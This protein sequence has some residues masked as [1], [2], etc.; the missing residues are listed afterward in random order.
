[1]HG[2]TIKTVST[3]GTVSCNSLPRTSRTV[4]T[5]KHSLTFAAYRC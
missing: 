4:S 3:D 2:A 1:M 5:T